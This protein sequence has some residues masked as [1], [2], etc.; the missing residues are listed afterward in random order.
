MPLAANALPSQVPTYAVPYDAQGAF[1][2]AQVIAATGYLNSIAGVVGT[3]Q[4]D[5]GSSNTVNASSSAGRVL[6]APGAADSRKLPSCQ[7]SIRAR[8]RRCQARSGVDRACVPRPGKRRILMD[9]ADEIILKWP[10]EALAGITLDRLEG[11]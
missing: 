10:D 8:T 1:S 9:E 5:L 7:P 2:S 4:I 3:G 6:P 11:A